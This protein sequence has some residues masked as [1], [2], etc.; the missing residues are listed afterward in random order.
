M[1]EVYVLLS[2]HSLEH[3]FLLVCFCAPS[4]RLGGRKGAETTRR[5][6]VMP[7]QKKPRKQP[8][9]RELNW[10]GRRV[11]DFSNFTE[12]GGRPMRIEVESEGQ[13]S[14]TWWKGRAMGEPSRSGCAIAS[15]SGQTAWEGSARLRVFAEGVG[16]A[17]VGF[18]VVAVTMG[19]CS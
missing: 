19:L 2:V 13:K 11:V 6:S 17:L 3:C 18:A 16:R 5:I 7:K 4:S 10:A 15:F 12:R 14:P 8:N 9:R 1:T